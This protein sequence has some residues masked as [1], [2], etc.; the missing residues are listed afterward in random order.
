LPRKSATAARSVSAARR[1]GSGIRLSWYGEIPVC[2]AATVPV[3]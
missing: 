3:H 1:W 2:A